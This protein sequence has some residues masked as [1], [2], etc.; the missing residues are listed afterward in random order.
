MNDALRELSWLLGWAHT[1][2]GWV[3][4][5]L[6]RHGGAWKTEQLPVTWLGQMRRAFEPYAQPFRRLPSSSVQVRISDLAR[7]SPLLEPSA[8]LAEVVPRARDA[9]HAL[10][11]HQTEEGRVYLPAV[12]LLS[13]L[14]VWT[15]GATDA[16]MTPN[17]LAVYL[18]RSDLGERLT[19]E[20]SGGLLRLGRSDTSLRRLCWLAQ[21]QDAR[22]SWSSVLTSAHQG[23]LDL[24]LPTASLE[25]WAWGVELPTGFLVAELSAASLRFELPQ[26]GCEVKLGRA[27]LRCP[28]APRR[29]SGMVSF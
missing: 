23:K 13:L 24:R 4:E 15:E 7:L 8:V 17:S 3:I 25:G 27:S 14:W 10:F 21:C 2:Q 18:Q 28:A 29:I 19:V 16:L 11:V 26:E 12:L 5:A 1:R 9:R 20:A 22:A 6:V